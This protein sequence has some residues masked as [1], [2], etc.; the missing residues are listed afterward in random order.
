MH[1]SSI[2][3]GFAHGRSKVDTLPFLCLPLDYSQGLWSCSHLDTALSQSNVVSPTCFSFCAYSDLHQIHIY[4]CDKGLY[5]SHSHFRL[6][7]GQTCLNVPSGTLSSICVKLNL[8]SSPHIEFEVLS[9]YPMIFF[10]ITNAIVI[11]LVT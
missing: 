10:C 4:S 11:Y 1:K 7:V 2:R 9:D 3:V 5:A 6:P 8:S